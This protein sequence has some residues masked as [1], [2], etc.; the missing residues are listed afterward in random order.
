MSKNIFRRLTLDR[1]KIF[2]YII[3]FCNEHFNDYRISELT[4]VGKSTLQKRCIINADNKEIWVD[5]YFNTDG[6]TTIQPK[7]GKYQDISIQIASYILQNMEYKPNI[8]TSSFSVKL[9]KEQ[10]NF[11]IEYFNDLSNCTKINETTGNEYILYKYRSSIGDTITFKYFNNATFQ[12]QGK[13][14]YLYSEVIALLAHYFPFNEMI[15]KQSEF[16]CIPLESNEIDDE[17]KELFPKAHVLFNSYD[18]MLKTIFSP[19]LALRKIDILLPDYSSFVHPA[20][21]TLEGYLIILLQKVGIDYNSK[22]GFIMFY[23]NLFQKKHFLKPEYKSKINNQE[24][25][26]AIEEIYNFY[27][28]HRHPLFHV[29]DVIVDTSIIER[30]S[31]ADNIINNVVELIEKN[32]DKFF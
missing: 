9:D 4:N 3:D 17:I 29:R 12:V 22:E 25:C 15:K 18:G 28:K 32:Y 23:E 7:V 27:H 2:T 21:R 11:I 6:T 30:K 24:K 20:L 13:P 5:F 1:G 31:K 19:S 10:F 14:C 26:I 8:H 16:Y